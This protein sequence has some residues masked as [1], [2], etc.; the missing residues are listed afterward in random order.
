MRSGNLAHPFPEESN[1]LLVAHTAN[2][3]FAPTLGAY[4]ALLAENIAKE[5]IHVTGNTAIDAQYLL[6]SSGKVI[7]RKTTKVLVTAHRRENWK[8]IPYISNAIK[9][10][11]ELRPELEFIFVVHPNPDVKAQVEA[12]LGNTPKVIITEPLDYLELQQCLAESI[13]V[14]TDSG[15]IQEEAPSYG[16]R[17][18]VL[19]ETTER[20][21]AVEL[22]Y[23]VLAGATDVN[24]IVGSALAM[25]NA[26]DFFGWNNP[27]GDG[28]ASNRIADTIN[29]LCDSRNV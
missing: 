19:R 18:V 3:H 7:I 29:L 2:L 26:D 17:V 23:S 13:L 14:L 25:L 21:E 22:G 16:K 27:F 20:P 10:L 28:L 5:K 1:R 4:K 6:V 8:N 11:S 9:K 15:G 12:C 24:R